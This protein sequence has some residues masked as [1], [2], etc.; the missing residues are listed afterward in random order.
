MIPDLWRLIASTIVPVETCKRDRDLIVFEM[1]HD[2]GR[3]RSLN[4]VRNFFKTSKDSSPVCA[5]WD[6]VR[7]L[8]KEII[9]KNSYIK[10]GFEEIPYPVRRAILDLIKDEEPPKLDYRTLDVL[11]RVLH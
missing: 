5:N 1:Y 8:G 4:S 9:K 2:I 11:R 7:I 3:M 6:D 10:H